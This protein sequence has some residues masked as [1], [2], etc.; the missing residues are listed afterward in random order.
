V[1]GVPPAGAVVIVVSGGVASTT[2]ALSVTK[3]VPSFCRRTLQVPSL[4]A[5][6]SWHGRVSKF[7]S[8]FH[9]SLG[10]DAFG[11]YLR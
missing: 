3:C 10:V 9:G 6:K 1:N 7:D 11:R 4:A 8:R 5:L 2:K